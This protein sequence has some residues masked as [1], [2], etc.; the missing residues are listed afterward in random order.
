MFIE[1]SVLPYI[2]DPK[3]KLKILIDIGSMKSFINKGL[4]SL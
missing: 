1:D 2:C 4:A 3:S